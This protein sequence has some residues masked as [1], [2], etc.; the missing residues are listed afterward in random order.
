MYREETAG[1]KENGTNGMLAGFLK[2]MLLAVI[3]TLFAFVA[4]SLLIAFTPLSESVI[5]T[6]SI[7]VMVISVLLG[8]ASFSKGAKSK[9]YLKGCMSGVAYVFIIYLLSVVLEGGM[10]FNAYVLVLLAIGVFVGSIGGIMGINM[11]DKRRR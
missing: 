1:I 9:G 5:P 4:F 7:A 6:A 10:Y 3:F 8:A 11:K 2:S